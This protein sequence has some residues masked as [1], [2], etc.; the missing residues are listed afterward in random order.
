MNAE[1]LAVVKSKD[2]RDKLIPQGIEPAAYTLDAY[3]T[4]INRERDRLGKVAAKAKM[5]AD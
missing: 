1:L 2:F 4:F 5:T 3:R